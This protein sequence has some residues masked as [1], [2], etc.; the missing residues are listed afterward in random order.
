MTNLRWKIVTILSVLV[1]FA[2][3]GVYPIVAS[4][5]GIHQ[6]SWLMEK[7]LKLGL[8]LQG[9]VHLELRVKT[10]DALAGETETEMLRLTDA[11]QKAGINAKLTQGDATHFRA[12]GVPPEKDAAFKDAANELSTNFDRGPAV[13]GA[14]TFAMR[15]NIQQQLGELRRLD[16]EAGQP[17]PDPGAVDL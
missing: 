5:Y 17:D 2:A 11:L 13:G 12:D 7:Q 3:V 4:H 1:I 9:G 15:P 14:Y 16:R 10:D 6:P 8:D